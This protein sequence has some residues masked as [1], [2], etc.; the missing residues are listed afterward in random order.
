M[1]RRAA[2][3][4]V[5]EKASSEGAPIVQPVQRLDEVLAEDAELDR[6]LPDAERLIA[7]AATLTTARTG[8]PKLATLVVQYWR[9][10]SDEEL[11][12]RTAQDLAAATA[13]HRELATQRL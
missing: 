8:D 2:A 11:A 9:L 1:K 13:S 3:A 10:V 12:G 7:E 4:D 5:D 6:P